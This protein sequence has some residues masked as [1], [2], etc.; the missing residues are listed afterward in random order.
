MKIT[1]VGIH[2]IHQSI[3][4]DK[5]KLS[6]DNQVEKYV[7]RFE[8]TLIN[9]STKLHQKGLDTALIANFSPHPKQMMALSRLEKDG[10]EVLPELKD[11]IEYYFKVH[12]H[13]NVI[14]FKPST[15]LELANF[16]YNRIINS[17]YVLTNFD[18]F[19]MLNFLNINNKNNIIAYNVLPAYRA[20]AFV[21]GIVL[22]QPP[23]NF[24]KSTKS[25]MQSG[26]GWIAI[27]DESFVHFITLKHHF[28]L[29]FKD[30]DE[31]LIEFLPIPNNQLVAW[32]NEHHIL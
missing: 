31:F 13:D 27:E 3:V 29:N 7:E 11:E 6:F 18:T 17:R 25:L 19:E 16:Q 30:V 15:K 23:S 8:K 9:L 28:K 10:V 24:E 21:Q 20:L 22:K 5:Q 4:V 12:T 26:L 32:L 2:Y 14:N 1:V